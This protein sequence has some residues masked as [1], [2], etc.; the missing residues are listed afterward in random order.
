[1]IK[2]KKLLIIIYFLI[3]KRQKIY[4]RKFSLLNPEYPQPAP[5]SVNSEMQNRTKQGY[6]DYSALW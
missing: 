1:M 3:K 2:D 4:I 6:I 5:F